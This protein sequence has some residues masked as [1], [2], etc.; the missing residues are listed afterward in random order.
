MF[1]F[2]WAEVSVV[3]G[4]L[5]TGGGMVDVWDVV[6]NVAGA[7]EGM[8]GAWGS[9]VGPFVAGGVFVHAGGFCMCPHISQ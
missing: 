5:G 9:G 7:V 4:S 2:A 6:C 1:V 8:V 3:V